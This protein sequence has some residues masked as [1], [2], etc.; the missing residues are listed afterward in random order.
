MKKLKNEKGAITLIVLVS[1]LFM[2]SFLISSYAIVANKAKTQKEIVEQTRAIYD[3]TE[4][5]EET[6]N[7]YFMTGEIIPI[8][9]VEQL[10][11]M[12]KGESIIIDGKY[13][14]FSNNDSTVYMLM[15]DLAFN[16][17]DYGENYYWTPMGERGEEWLAGFIGNNH[18]IEV[19]Y[20]DTEDDEYSV[21]YSEE[22]D[23]AEP[24]YK[25]KVSPR[26]LSESGDILTE[27]TIY[28]SSNHAEFVAQEGKGEME[29]SVKRLVATKI[30]AGCEGYR[31]SVTETITIKNPNKIPEINLVLGNY[32]FTINAT[33]EDA[34][35]TINGVEKTTVSVNKGEQVSWKVEATGYVTKEGTYT[36]EDDTTIDVSLEV[37]KHTF[38]INATPTDAVVTIDGEER[39]S[40][41]VDYGT[42]IS[43][44]VVRDEYYT[45]QGN[46]TVCE[47]MTL[48]VSL[49]EWVYINFSESFYFTRCSDETFSGLL[50]GGKT[51]FEKYNLSGKDYSMGSFFLDEA[52]IVD[53]VPTTATIAKVTVYFDYYQDRNNTFLYTN[54]IKTTIYA[55]DTEKMEEDESE[56]TNKDIQTAK[57]ELTNIT[58]EELANSLRVDLVNYIEGTL[59]IDSTVENLYCVIEG[60]YPDI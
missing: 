28:T 40:I 26:V 18:K 48:D 32:S 13:Y 49:E 7:S 56:K 44:S 36:V 24:E 60:E 57:Y 42:T 52:D 59:E 35:V 2:V 27:A 34:K 14:I 41:T 11:A 37:A 9:T 55:G 39:N 3:N 19:K 5:I 33:P 38:T 46:I 50:N 29:I 58:R 22:N 16:A 31:N 15:N 17:Y 43:Y 25:V 54:T 21:I 53:K 51:T 12:G 1:I 6:Y 45:K 47:D 4:N 20:K 8:Y 30:Y 23:F 10:F